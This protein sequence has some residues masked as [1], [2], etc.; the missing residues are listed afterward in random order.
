MADRTKLQMKEY[1]T[2]KERKQIYV[3]QM[4]ATIAPKYDRVTSWLSYGQDKKWKRELVEL[5]KIEPQHQVL[6][7]ACG[8][9]DITFMLAETLTTGRAVGVD[10]TPGMLEIANRKK[11][12]MD[13]ETI[14]F[15]LG[16][17]MRLGFSDDQFDRITVGYGLRN[18][19][20]LPR[21]LE[22]VL[23]LLKP[24]GRFL[25]LDFGKPKNRIYRELY[26]RY[27]TFVGSSFGWVLHGDPDVYRYIPESLK[28]YPAQDGV[29]T[30]MEAAGFK[31][32]GYLCYL[33]G[34]TAINYGVK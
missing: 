33:G 11:K 25:S 30:L 29:K 26:L 4:F 5:A 27:L 16:D 31:E 2:S 18:V 24:G 22:E 17:I 34:A 23:R 8:T 21:A 1:I 10:I 14:Q 13:L 12:A 32:T 20:D 19:P 9:G 3:N 6:D 15:E 7:L 28:L